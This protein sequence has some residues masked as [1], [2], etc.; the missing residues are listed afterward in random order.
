V[1]KGVTV[2]KPVQD[3]DD[4]NAAS[5]NDDI[6]IQHRLRQEPDG[7]QRKLEEFNAIGGLRRPVKAFAKVPGL[8]GVGEAIHTQLC[9][10]FE[11]HQEAIDAVH[12][13]IGAD[14]GY[15]IPQWHIEHVRAILAEVVGATDTEP[16]HNDDYQTCVRAN[17]L[18]AWRRAAGDPDDQPEQW[19]QLGAPAGIRQAPLDRKIFPVLIDEMDDPE[20]LGSE[21]QEYNTK[22][23]DNMEVLEAKFKE[24]TNKGYVKAF[25]SFSELKAFLDGENPVFSEIHVLSKTKNGRTKHRI[26]LD[27]KKAGLSRSSRR[28]ERTL[29]PRVTDAVSDA[30]EMATDEAGEHD[31]MLFGVLD[32]T[33]AFWMIPLHKSERRFFTTKVGQTFYVFL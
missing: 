5:W 29:L 32:F 16:V 13:G 17:L 25:S 30:M 28:S 12:H 26:I 1:D 6:E 8:A 23:G 4:T 2:A 24:F 11:E 21:E 22:E 10:Y 18:A 19:L 33:D 15:Q 9:K 7:D 27:C 14:E 31:T 3:A 20:L